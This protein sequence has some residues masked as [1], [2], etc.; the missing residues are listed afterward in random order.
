M[1][2]KGYPKVNKQVVKKLNGNRSGKNNKKNQSPFLC[3]MLIY[4]GEK[5]AHKV[6]DLVHNFIKHFRRYQ[7]ILRLD[8]DIFVYWL[9]NYMKK[10]I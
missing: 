8:L 3:K 1:P 6:G 2:V 5:V 4:N 7:V 10:W 9:R